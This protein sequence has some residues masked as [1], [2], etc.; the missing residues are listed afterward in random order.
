MPSEKGHRKSSKEDTRPTRIKIGYHPGTGQY[1][2]YIRGKTY[3]F[4]SDR[5]TALARYAFFLETGLVFK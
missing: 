4:G 1:R 3:Y 5:E 2:K